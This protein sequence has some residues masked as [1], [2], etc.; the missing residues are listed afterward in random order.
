M[1]LTK[2]GREWSSPAGVSFGITSFPQRERGC[3]VWLGSLPGND[4]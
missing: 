3:D 1:L 2:G 4:A